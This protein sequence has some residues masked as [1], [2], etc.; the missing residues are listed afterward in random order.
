M[1]FLLTPTWSKMMT[2]IS[3]W[4]FLLHRLAPSD[5]KLIHQGF[6]RILK[7]GEK[8]NL[9]GLR[10]NANGG[11]ICEANLVTFSSRL[12]NHHKL[13]A[14]WLPRAL[15]LIILLILPSPTKNSQTTLVTANLK[16][17]TT[18]FGGTWKTDFQVSRATSTTIHTFNPVPATAHTATRSGVPYK[19]NPCLLENLSSPKYPKSHHLHPRPNK[20]QAPR[21]SNPPNPKTQE[22]NAEKY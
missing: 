17:A 9:R 21:S 2:M 22:P 14:G 16:S 3:E 7:G 10:S 12:P 8:K 11:A 20:T 18:A 19:L 6:L 13:H 1:T 5:S 15:L 4:T